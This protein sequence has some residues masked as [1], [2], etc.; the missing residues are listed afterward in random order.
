MNKGVIIVSKSWDVSGD[1]SVDVL[2]VTVVFK[3]LVVGVY[4]DRVSD[5]DE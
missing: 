4:R 3:V 1:L 2:W 5:T